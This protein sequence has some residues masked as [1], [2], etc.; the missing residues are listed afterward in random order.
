MESTGTVEIITGLHMGDLFFMLQGAKRTIILTLVSISFGTI[1]GLFIGILRGVFNKYV[2]YIF[3]L[4]LDFVRSVPLIIQFILVNAYFGISGHAKSPFFIGVLVLSIYSGAYIS[5]VVRA[6][7]LA[8]PL[9]TRRAARSLGLSWFHDLFYI[10]FP[11]GARAVFPSWINIVIGLFKDTSLIA[12]IGYIELL[13]A[14]EIIITRTWEPMLVLGGV[15]LFYFIICYPISK[16]SE[17][18][19]KKVLS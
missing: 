14:G 5:E 18:F 3:G 1:L 12:V 11:I 19:E 4:F 13:R 7:V 15:G 8:V 9:T 10:V 6:G 16:W 17:R 2:N